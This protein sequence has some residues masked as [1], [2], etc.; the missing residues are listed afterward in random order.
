MSPSIP[1][2]PHQNNA[3]LRLFGPN[4]NFNA[5]PEPGSLGM[6]ALGIAAVVWTGV[7]KRLTFRR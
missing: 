4:A 5:V 7:M 1:R 6:F 3:E 2:L